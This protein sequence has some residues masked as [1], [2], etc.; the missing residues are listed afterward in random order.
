LGT[1][2]CTSKEFPAPQTTVMSDI[3]C[4][5]DHL[6]PAKASNMKRISQVGLFFVDRDA[7]SFGNNQASYQEIV[8]TSFTFSPLLSP[9]QVCQDCVKDNFDGK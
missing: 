2:A 9:D 5:H 4:K 8:E 6:D 1:A 7:Y 3:L